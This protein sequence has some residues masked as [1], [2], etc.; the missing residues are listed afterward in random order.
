MSETVTGIATWLRIERE[1]MTQN[2]DAEDEQSEVEQEACGVIATVPASP[3]SVASVASAGSRSASQNTISPEAASSSSAP[4]GSQNMP[5][6]MKRSHTVSTTIAT[7]STKLQL[8][9]TTKTD[10]MTMESSTSAS[11]VSERENDSC[12]EK[13]KDSVWEKDPR[14]ESRAS[15]SSAATLTNGWYSPALSGVRAARVRN[16]K[17]G[18]ESH[19][20]LLRSDL[21]LTSHP[22]MEIDYYDYEV[23]NAGL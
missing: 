6:P 19:N 5:S 13:D 15:S 23:N 20:R 4:A 22:E 18:K 8:Q 16:P 9:N 12:S 1:I 14:S 3:N 11:T 21:S 7:D 17:R 10:T 2:R